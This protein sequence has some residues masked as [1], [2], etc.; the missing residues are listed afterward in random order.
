MQVG[1]DILGDLWREGL[2]L[3]WYLIC[4]KPDQLS[5]SDS[6]TVQYYLR[7]TV[8]SPELLQNDAVWVSTFAGKAREHVGTN[9]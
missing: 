9:G 4:V 7:V 3:E 2:C 5:G 8:C 6:K 1:S